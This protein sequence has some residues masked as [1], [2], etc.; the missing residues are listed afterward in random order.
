MSGH[1]GIRDTRNVWNV[2]ATVAC[3]A[4]GRA[5][6]EAKAF[7]LP[8]VLEVSGRIT[9]TQF[10]FDTSLFMTYTPTLTTPTS[11]ASVSL[12][13]YDSATGKPFSSGG[14]EVCAPCTF[15]LSAT[16]R[17]AQLDL[18]D[19]IFPE[20]GSAQ[21]GA[22][23]GFG[24]FV[25]SGA[26]PDGVAIQGFVVNS[27]SGPFDLSVFG[28]DPVP[29]DVAAITIGPAPTNE[30]RRVFVLPHVLEAS[31]RVSSTPFTFDTQ[32]FA[33][34]VGGL[35][36]A[37]ESGDPGT[38]GPTSA[39]VDIYLRDDATDGPLLTVEG[40]VVC[41]PCQLA[42]DSA[43]RKVSFSVEQAFANAGGRMPASLT[44]HAV[45]VVKGDI[46]NVAVSGFVTNSH[47][48]AFDLSACVVQ[49]D[50]V[51][52]S[53]H[54]KD[55]GAPPSPR[56]VLV[57]PHVLEASGRIT[58]TQF[59]FD[60]QIFATYSSGI[61]PGTV[62]GSASLELYLL[63][64]GTGEALR[65]LQG[66]DVCNPCAYDF[67]PG[68]ARKA[69]ISIDDLIL[70]RG[71]FASKAPSC[72]AVIVV[73][74]ADPDGVSVQGFVVNSHSSALDLSIAT[75]EPQ[76]LR[77]DPDS[78]PAETRRV[79][80]LPHVLEASGRITNTQ[81]TF[82]TSLFMDYTPGKGASPG[83]QVDLYLLDSSTGAPLKSKNSSD[84]CAPCA[85]TLGSGSSSSRTV[86]LEEVILAA[87]GLASD[88]TEAFVVADVTGDADGVAI[89]GFVVNAHTGPFDLAVFGFDPVPIAAAA[90]VRKPV[91]VR[92][93][94]NGDGALDLSDAIASLSYLF[95]GGEAPG[96]LKA[97]DANG[98]DGVDISDPIHL[99]GFLFL[100]GAGPAAPFPECGS[101]PEESDLSCESYSRC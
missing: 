95:T 66:Q 45:A 3:L 65:S 96:C 27:H 97:A 47:T 73:G 94:A 52:G 48:S 21:K 100:G 82:D 33:T 53:D 75:I 24:V 38:P 81:F 72:R 26:D 68:L 50:V 84:V 1:R 15:D 5:S 98:K 57:L 16:D 49:P 17:T 80:V 54:S 28:F 46:P 60:T 62:E 32:I 19:V 41:N 36:G 25:V 58:D 90:I 70:A 92:G 85:Y 31:G 10:T 37:L 42:L 44:G 55:P 23:V 43:A 6:A 78:P 99:L 34:Y 39:S 12:Y 30:P 101:E 22:K 86:S 89:Q 13:L 74:G 69:S 88:V 64:N 20:G 51:D 40:T 63:D 56:R 29:I 77:R 76:P 14:A 61:V 9:E 2:I 87:G 59:T 11:D 8:H 91:F 79:L 71:G 93:D 4:L 83:A 18:E 67:G 35:P 7:V